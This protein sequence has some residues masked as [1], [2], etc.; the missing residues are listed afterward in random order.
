MGWVHEQSVVAFARKV[1]ERVLPNLRYLPQSRLRTCGACQHLTVIIAFGP[2]DEVKLCLRCRANLRYEMLAE[3]IR[4]LFPDL[5]QI[6]VLELDYASPLR[7]LLSRARSYTRSFYR[8]G[9]A[10]GTVRSDGA[11]CQD[12]TRLTFGDGSL[13]LIVSSDVLEHVPDAQAAFTESMRVLRPGGAHLFTVPPRPATRQ[14]AFLREGAIVHR[15]PPEYHWDPLDP[16]GV[17]VFWDYGPDMA[18]SLGVQGLDLKI[19]SGPRGVDQRIVWQA[20]KP[21]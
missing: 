20:M 10:P 9:I 8:A 11:V 19:V 12:I 16:A 6:D 17:L 21:D 15:L 2:E 13:D 5:A 3:R 18:A 4:A 14:R 7:P 1:R